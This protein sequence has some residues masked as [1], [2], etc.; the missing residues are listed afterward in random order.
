M[1]E[2]L[3][4][5]PRRACT[6]AVFKTAALSRPQPAL[7]EAGSRGGDRSE[8][9]RQLSGHNRALKPLSY[10]HPGGNRRLNA[11]RRKDLNFHHRDLES[12]ALP[13]SYAGIV[14]KGR[15]LVREGG[16]EPPISCFQDTRPGP[17]WTIPL[18]LNW[19]P[20]EDSNLES[21]G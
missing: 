18:T 16:F 3:G 10:D 4:F 1:E 13:L 8:S 14:G 21:S 17:G 9:N 2:G 15:T 5:E 20:P 6:L 19:H 12:R 11:H 7:L